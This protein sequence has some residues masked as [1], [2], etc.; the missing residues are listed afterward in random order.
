ML[1]D[2]QLVLRQLVE[3]GIYQQTDY[4]NLSVSL[5]SRL[6]AGKQ[7]HRQFKND[8]AI[9]NLLCG[10]HDTTT[11]ELKK[12]ELTIRN[13]F[14][15]RSSPGLRQFELD[16]LK[17]LNEHLMI[18]LNYRPRFGAFADAGINAVN[19]GRIPNNLGTSVGLSF[20][21][22]LYDGKQRQFEHEKVSLSEKTREKYRSSFE[23]RYQ[24][25]KD[26][27]S[28][29]LILSDEIIADMKKQISELEKLI[30]IYQ[31]EF[32]RGLVRW[33]DFIDV[34]NNY[35]QV[36]NDFSQTEINRLQILNQLN[37]LK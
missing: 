8:L 34:V 13:S 24:Q 23:N 36:L 30:S 7:I 18:D 3:K 35:A 32:N 19:P 1:R 33:L 17:L 27:Y 31:A 4:L 6:I 2:Q 16:S 20:V 22:P 25:Q 10:I 28:E 12:P 5:D 26:Q 29:Q 37:Y 21:M 9:L 11:P 15:I 14:D